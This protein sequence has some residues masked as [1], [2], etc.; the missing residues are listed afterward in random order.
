MHPDSPTSDDPRSD[1][2]AHA[3][4]QRQR[5][6]LILA[7]TQSR[8]WWLPFAGRR[9]RSRLGAN[10][11]HEINDPEFGKNLRIFGRLVDGAI[12]ARPPSPTIA[13]TTYGWPSW[14][15]RCTAASCF[16]RTSR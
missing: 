14:K 5:I 3:C 11:T 6:D 10:W 13:D 1:F 8:W 15:A 9:L 12:D 4:A 2:V 7:G 16:R